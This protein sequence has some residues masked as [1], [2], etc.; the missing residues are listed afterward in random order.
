M[1]RWLKR[2]LIGMMSLP[3]LTVAAWATASTPSRVAYQWHTFFGG[4]ASDGANLPATVTDPYG[5]LYV[6]GW[7]LFPWDQ[8]GKPTGTQL[9]AWQTY[10]AKISPSGQLLWT[11]YYAGYGQSS[12]GLQATAITLDLQGHVYIAGNG[13]IE[14]DGNYG[15]F[16]METDSE[17]YFLGGKN[18]GYSNYGRSCA[19]YGITYDR[20]QHFVY[21]TG[22]AAVGWRGG[23]PVNSLPTNGA[24]AMFILQA[25]ESV[26]GLALG[27]VGFYYNADAQG[28]GTNAYGHAITVDY[29][30]DLY[31]AGSE[32]WNRAAAVWKVSNEGQQLWEVTEPDN[33]GISYALAWYGSSVY[34][35]GY[36]QGGWN[37]PSGQ[38]PLNAFDYG[39][40]YICCRSVAFVM[41]LDTDGNYGWHTFYYGGAQASIGEGIA[42]DGPTTIYVTGPGDIVGFNLAPPL[43]DTVG[44]GGGGH[45]IL[46]LDDTGAYQ[47]HSLYGNYRWDEASSIA[48]DSAHNVLVSGWSG[49]NSWLGDNY[50]PPLH[51]ANTAASDVFVMKFGPVLPISTHT[52]VDSVL[53]IIYSPIPQS[54]ELHAAVTGGGSSINSGTVSFALLGTSAHIITS[55]VTNGSAWAFSEIPGG[56]TAGSYTIQAT[57]NPGAGFAGS[58]DSSQQLVIGKAT[59]V[60]TWSNP[61]AIFFG[62][63]LGPTQLNATANVSG[64]FAY[65]PPAGTVPQAGNGQTL[66]TTFT[67][68]DTANYIP[69]SASAQINVQPSTPPAS[70]A[71]IVVTKSLARNGSNIVVS[72]SISNSGGVAAQNVQLTVGKI[73]TTSGTPLPQL[74]G[75]GTV[76]AGATV[77]A[78]LTFPGTVGT[79]GTAAVLTVSGT[80]TG[81]SF[82]NS[83]RITLP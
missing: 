64:T 8:Y 67:P 82:N 23:Q 58:S 16:V 3:A 42:V 54:V 27:W 62:T 31:V 55:S 7:T 15:C 14:N 57:Y 60:I 30:S 83:G 43:H 18:I 29:A 10:L 52:T 2:F 50:T 41:K 77:T 25:Q 6:T 63:A 47:W 21:V 38:A 48:V 70:P 24:Q 45:F 78:T 1:S 75:G 76:A 19:V 11:S 33:S 61:A 44:T 17:G 26:S 51:A 74:V 56:T 68:A 20:V 32:N 13:N 73:Q 71:Q 12:S 22:L 72:L 53:P 81:G 35:T 46:Q 40:G 34:I 65:T 5:N 4:D 9:N 36:S 66:S 28:G 80:Y 59:P 49:Y 37:G 79:P 69:A 39:P